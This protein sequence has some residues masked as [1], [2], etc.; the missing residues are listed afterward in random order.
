MPPP[1]DYGGL[2]TFSIN[3]FT[4]EPE[5]ADCTNISYGCTV[6]PIPEGGEM[7]DICS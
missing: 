3:P 5:E 7:C 4:I 2:L 6:D 1:Y